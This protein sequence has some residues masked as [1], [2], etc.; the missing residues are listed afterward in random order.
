[1]DFSAFDTKKMDEYAAEAK[2]KWGKTDAYAEYEKKSEGRSKGEEQ[3]LGKGLMDILAAFGTMKDK[4]ADAPET[5]Q[6]VKKLQA[7]ITEHYYTCTK[8]ILA[9][10]GQMYAAGGEFTENIDAAGGK[11]TAEFVAEAIVGYCK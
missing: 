2:A 9:G 8:Q 7:Y 10:L 3:D 6:Q 5:Q 1:M 11:G 4:G